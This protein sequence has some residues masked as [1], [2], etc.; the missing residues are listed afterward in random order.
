LYKEAD[1]AFV[2]RIRDRNI[3]IHLLLGSKRIVNKALE[4]A[5]ELEAITLQPRHLP[6]SGMQ[7]PGHSG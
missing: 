6:G 3:K 4:P 2:N 7:V 1:M 5:S